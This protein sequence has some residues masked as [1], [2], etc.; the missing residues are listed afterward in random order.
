MAIGDLAAASDAD[1]FHDTVR[2]S[3]VITG[4]SGRAHVFNSNGRHITSLVI[5]RDKLERLCARKRY[6][7]LTAGE[8]KEFREAV[9]SI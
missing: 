6:V 9:A 5:P 8:R 1:L 3:I 4:R 7:L 2:Q